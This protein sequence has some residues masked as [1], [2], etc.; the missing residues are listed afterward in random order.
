MLHDPDLIRD[1]ACTGK[2]QFQDHESARRAAK[3]QSDRRKNRV[4]LS[5][6]KCEFCDHFH[7]GKEPPR[8]IKRKH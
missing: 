6:Y 1:A 5:V 3:H 7:V 8:K 2:Q 4:K